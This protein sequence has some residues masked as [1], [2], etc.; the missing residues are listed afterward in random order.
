[1]SWIAWIVIAAGAALALAVVVW[2]VI[3]PR[4]PES[5]ATHDALAERPVDGG[6][7]PYEPGAESQR[8]EGRGTMRPGPTE[9]RPG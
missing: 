8:P 1:M 7:P 6:E 5:A 3:A 9:S 4:H 2:F